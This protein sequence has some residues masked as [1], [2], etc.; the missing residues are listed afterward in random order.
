MLPKYGVGHT[1]PI[2]FCED[3]LSAALIQACFSSF[4]FDYIIRQKIV[5]THLTYGY[6]YQLPVPSLST[7]HSAPGGVRW[8]VDRTCSA[9]VNGM[10]MPCRDSR[11]SGQTI[12]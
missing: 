4:A 7:F 5:G 11:R 2:I 1:N 9:N 8:F 12:T 10:I 6:L 3:P